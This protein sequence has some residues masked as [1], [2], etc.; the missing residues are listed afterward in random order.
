MSL[1]ARIFTNQRRANLLPVFLQ[2]LLII[3]LQ[4]GY[5][6]KW[7]WEDVCRTMKRSARHLGRDSFHCNG[8]TDDLIGK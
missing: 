1:G 7:K 6:T 8:V 3:M 4:H 5:A 2:S